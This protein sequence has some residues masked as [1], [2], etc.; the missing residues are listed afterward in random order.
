MPNLPQDDTSGPRFTISERVRIMRD[1]LVNNVAPLT[2]ALVGLVLVPLMLH[3]LG[4][5]TYGLWLAALALAGL[6]QEFDFGL[7]WSIAR[8]VAAAEAAGSLADEVRFVRASVS[9]CAILGVAG[10]AAICAAGSVVAG[11]MALS[12]ELLATAPTI[13]ACVALA[14]VADHVFGVGIGILYGLRR[15]ATLNLLMTATTIARSGGFAAILL[16]GGTVTAIAAWHAGVSITAAII[17]HLWIRRTSPFIGL[18]PGRLD[19]S[20]I[21]PHVPFGV[22]SALIAFA[23]GFVWQAPQLLIGAMLGS[24]SIATYHVGLRFPLAA[25]SI[26]ERASSTIFPAASFHRASH[27]RSTIELL[28]VSTRLAFLFTVPVCLVLWAVGEPLLHLWLGRSASSDLLLVYYLG[29]IGLLVNATCTCAYQVLWATG[30]TRPLIVLFAIVGIADVSL[31]LTSVAWIGVIGAAVALLAALTLQAIGLL[32]I[33][34]RVF[35]FS[36]WRLLAFALDGTPLAFATC[37]ATA[38]LLVEV[39]PAGWVQIILLS[40]VASIAYGVVLYL[41]GAREEERALV[42]TPLA[43]LVTMLRA[44]L[45]SLARR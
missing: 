23:S 34:S 14:F 40:S 15:F 13:F 9:A 12:N 6:I 21:G 2:G 1:A 11:S 45:R 25:M 27:E 4:S 30:R 24:P 7:G 36:L 43:K 42:K 39:I 17:G 28:E 38:M 32:A 29:C 31:T 19:W 20:A 10:G 26:V 35:N 41:T 3:G 8:S 33:A 37:L 44:A 16:L 18:A 5:E 22:S